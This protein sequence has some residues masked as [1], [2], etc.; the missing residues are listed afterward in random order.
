MS[1]IVLLM[2]VAVMAGCAGHRA[3]TEMSMSEKESTVQVQYLEIVTPDVDA[4]CAAYALGLRIERSVRNGLTGVISDV[5]PPVAI[6][7]SIAPVTARNVTT[8]M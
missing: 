8:L 3:E 4:V 1:R 7:A 5:F 6:T 2:L